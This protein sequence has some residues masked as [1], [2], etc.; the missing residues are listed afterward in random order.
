MTGIRILSVWRSGDNGSLAGVLAEDAT[1]SSPVA[2]YRGR[3]DAAHILGLVARVLEDVEK[4][5]EWDAGRETVSAFAARARGDHLQ[6]MLC[7]RRDE[8]GRVV[9]VTLFLRPYRALT[10]AIERMRELLAES[11][12]P[13]TSTPVSPRSV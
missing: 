12:L 5:G 13:S 3:A 6:G 2:D 7:E 9:H 4:T 8:A 11:P 10:R 1:F